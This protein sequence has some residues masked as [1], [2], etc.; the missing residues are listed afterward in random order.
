[1]YVGQWNHLDENQTG[2]ERINTFYISKIFKSCPTYWEG[3][4]TQA[5]TELEWSNSTLRV[6]GCK[7][8]WAYQHSFYVYNYISPQPF[9]HC[10]WHFRLSKDRAVSD[11]GRG[12]LFAVWVCLQVGEST[13]RWVELNAVIKVTIYMYMYNYVAWDRCGQSTVRLGGAI[14]GDRSS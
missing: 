9:R 8:R 12:K 7:V 2:Q 1:M 13:S 14:A 6:G 11:S 10:V 5:Q 4:A 3:A